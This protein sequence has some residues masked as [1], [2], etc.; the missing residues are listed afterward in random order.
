MLHVD[1]PDN[2]L[3][4]VSVHGAVQEVGAISF[5]PTNEHG[6]YIAVVGPNGKKPRQATGSVTVDT[7][8]TLVRYKFLWKLVGDYVKLWV[9]NGWS[10]GKQGTHYAKK[11]SV[12]DYIL[13]N[14]TRPET[15]TVREHFRNVFRIE[16]ETD[17]IYF[18][19]QR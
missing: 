9:K 11:R 15:N 14:R 17:T 18:I 4:D 10:M 12:L 5:K 19:D 2:Y 8:P 1:H 3:L 6:Q 16:A 7:G 13:E